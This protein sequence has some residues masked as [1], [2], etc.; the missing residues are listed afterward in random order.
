MK[1]LKIAVIGTINQDV[2]I[3]PNKKR[4]TS[5]GGIAYNICTL[6]ALLKNQA[7]IFPICNVGANRYPQFLKFFSKFPNLKLNGIK[8][9][10]QKHNTCLMYY[11][12]NQNRE[13][14]LQGK[15]PS[16]NFTQLKPFLE[17]YAILINFISGWDMSLVTLKKIRKQ[18]QGIILLDIHSL[19]LEIDKDHKR[20]L[21]KPKNWRAYAK[22][23]D[24]LQM[25][26]TELET[27]LN[28]KLKS[29]DLISGT[30]NILKLGP[31][32]FILTLEEDGA[33]ICWKV[34]KKICLKKIAGI[35]IKKAV[36]NIGCGDIFG[37]AFL[38]DY[39][40]NKN[41]IK[42]ALLANYLAAKK[43]QFSGVEKIKNFRQIKS[44]FT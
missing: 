19:T 35:P 34:G 8:K 43:C 21:R 38:A 11:G 31:K 2:I 32:I 42:S 33:I 37:A 12:Q 3:F 1:P 9:V 10:P 4:K 23:C 40:I 6:A 30:K 22:C 25:N 16:L 29:D 17:F 18:F 39:L 41:I 44:Y 15:V 13:E 36:D 5:L 28:K 27:V 7:Q 20:L 24:I 26:K 14:Y